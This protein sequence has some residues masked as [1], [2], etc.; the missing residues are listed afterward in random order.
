MTNLTKDF[1]L[2]SDEDIELF[3]DS[4][5]CSKALISSLKNRLNTQSF[6]NLSLRADDHF[7]GNKKCVANV[8]ISNWR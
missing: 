5:E 2:V 7:F 8:Q 1:D 3:A 6:N 4:M